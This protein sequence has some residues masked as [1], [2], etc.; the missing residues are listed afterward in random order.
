[1]D[2]SR[3]TA[4]VLTAGLLMLAA[5]ACGQEPSAAVA[6]NPASTSSSASTVA[7]TATDVPALAAP[8]T[9]EP[10][11]TSE[12]SVTSEPTAA[13]PPTA[14]PDDAVSNAAG[15]TVSSSDPTRPPEPTAVV[16]EGMAKVAAPIESVEIIVAESFPP[17]YFVHVVSG[18]PN[19]CVE[20][21]G[22]EE[23]RDGNAITITVANLEPAPTNNTLAC[24][25]IYLTH[26][27]SVALGT[28][29]ES[30]ETYT[31]KVND[32]VETIVAQ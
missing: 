21:Y 7:P 2:M 6:D 28:D 5:V 1:M 18:L 22:Y 30:G 23:T 27:T 31:V 8:S 19:G 24:A 29:F 3:M 12:P 26:E 25:A 11:V 13:P 32:I 16:P 9:S 17:Q 15:D 14:R 20:F 4:L 10:D